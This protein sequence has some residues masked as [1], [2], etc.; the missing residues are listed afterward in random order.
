M[1]VGGDDLI[2]RALPLLHALLDED[3]VVADVHHG[4]HV[5]GVDHGGHLILHRDVVNQVVD[6]EGGLRVE[7]GVGFV[8][9]KV[10]RVERDGSCD[11]RTLHH[12][13]TDLRGVE[14]A[15]IGQVDTL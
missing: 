11:G 13:A 6:Q 14:V 5:V 2:F 15:R 9:E 1:V 7:A 3:D 12:T 10:L 4:V 8:A